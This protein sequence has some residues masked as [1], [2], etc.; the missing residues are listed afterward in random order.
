MQQLKS[1]IEGLSKEVKELKLENAST[2][3]EL[4]DSKLGEGENV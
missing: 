3:T 4:V 2:Q 1:D